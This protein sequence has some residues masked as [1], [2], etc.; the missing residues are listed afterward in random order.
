[1]E[2]TTIAPFSHIQTAP[3]EP[4]DYYTIN[5]A[6][7]RTYDVLSSVILCASHQYSTSDLSA[8]IGYST[9][10][11]Y[12]LV[13]LATSY[14]DIVSSNNVSSIVTH[15]IVY[16]YMTNMMPLCTAYTTSSGVGITKG[17][18]TLVNDIKFEY[19]YQNM[20][21]TGDTL[22]TSSLSFTDNLFSLPPL[23]YTQLF[24]ANLSAYTLSHKLFTSNIATSGFDVSVY[25]YYNTPD[26][27]TRTLSSGITW[28]AI[29][30]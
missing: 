7:T 4:I 2:R 20:A 25:S 30:V 9:Y 18:G 19:G 3:N 14:T 11:D 29:G 23:V 8:N 17:N 1:M 22:R 10:D 16:S 21:L 28:M 24:D 13:K 27:Y 15:D 26:S 12:G 5:R 6:F